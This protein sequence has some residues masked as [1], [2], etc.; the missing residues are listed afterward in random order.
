M[1]RLKMKWRELPQ[2][3][4]DAIPELVKEHEKQAKEKAAKKGKK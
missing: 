4:K 3:V 2:A 1:S